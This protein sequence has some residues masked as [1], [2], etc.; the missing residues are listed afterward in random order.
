M[1]VYKSKKMRKDGVRWGFN[2]YYVDEL[3][4]KQ[5]RITK[6]TYKTKREAENAERMMLNKLDNGD[7]NPF[8]G[9]RKEKVGELFDDWIDY[10]ARTGVTE[11][12]VRITE[13]G[14][15]KHFVGNFGNHYINK[16]TSAHLGNFFADLA[17]KLRNYRTYR[18]YVS[19][20]FEYAI[21]KGIITVNPMN[22]LPKLKETVDDKGNKEIIKTPV[23]YTE[24]ELDVL[25]KIMR[26]NIP[27]KQY[28]YFTL[29]AYTGLRKSEA[30]SLRKNDIDLDKMRITVNKTLTVGRK[31]ETVVAD[32][33]K[34]RSRNKDAPEVLP[35]HPSLREPLLNY[36]R[37][38]GRF[39]E[40]E[41]FFPSHRNPDGHL[42]MSA[43]DK[44]LR[45]FYNK[46]ES[47][48]RE[49]GVKH[50]ISVHG[51]RHTFVSIMQAKNYNPQV[52][53]YLTRHKNLSTTELYTH[54]NADTIEDLINLYNKKELDS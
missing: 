26:D 36:I 6:E 51:F 54:F 3:T 23:Y 50:R 30:L 34:S 7:Y 24:K 28:T 4:G 2:I 13:L 10:Y 8:F 20:F 32:G 47:E 22:N 18:Y 14:M 40:T 48:L 16:I 41:F 17:L 49:N 46:H 38:T 31:G 9:E 53:Q 29:L 45:T 39:N 33:T 27:I 1:S 25:L 52:T 19:Q 5:K 15:R 44:W 12:T 21:S 35:L 42:S 11:S 37:K 43:P